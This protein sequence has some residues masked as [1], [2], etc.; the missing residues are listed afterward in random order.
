M[1]NK[2]EL[3]SPAGDLERLK[4]AVIYGADAVYVGGEVF[5]L[6]A[7]AKNFSYEELCKGV[8]YA[9]EK[10]VKVYVTANII[11]HNKDLIGLPKYVK[12]LDKIGVDGIIVSDP[13]T[14]SIIRNTTPS[15]E[16]HISTQANN[17]NYE[18][19]R[20]W[21]RLG[22]KRV[23]LA[24]ELS[25]DEIKEMRLNLPDSVE[26]EAFVHGA[27][28]ISYSGRCLLSNYLIGRDANRGECAHTCRW[29]YHLVEER[30]PG[31]YLP[32]FED[33]KGSYIMNSKD[34][35]MIEHI[36]EIIESGIQSL[37]IEGRMKTIY[38]VATVTRAYR[39]AIDS[40]YKS[41]KDWKFNTEWM[42]EIKKASHREFTTGFYFKKPDHKEHVY[43][44]DPYIRDYSFIGIIKEYDKKTGVATIQQRNRFFSG[45]E[46]EI[47]GPGER[48]IKMVI[49]KMWNDEGKII[50][51]APHPQQTVKFVI[52]EKVEP[53][54]ILRKKQTN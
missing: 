26:L 35:C 47:I 42:K 45:D 4:I 1:N 53:Y 36:P 7:G 14:F 11:P 9:H 23:V 21:H 37:K 49:S 54:Y 50:D 33:E 40:Y 17:T 32:V 3:L 38:Y 2:V 51:V 12:E 44:E 15:M 18:T 19:I 48:V 24:R 6:R 52:N 43:K 20:F 5:G 25:F 30:R 8:D 31:E 46:I 29:R 39:H 13:G 22:A 27:M 34:L 10:G 41:P 16:I 28:C